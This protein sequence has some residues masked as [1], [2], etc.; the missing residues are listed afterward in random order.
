MIVQLFFSVPFLLFFGLYD[1]WFVEDDVV[2]GTLN[3]VPFW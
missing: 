3:E 2:I 1:H